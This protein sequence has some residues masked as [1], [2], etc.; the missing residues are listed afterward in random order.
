MRGRGGKKAARQACMLSSS[1]SVDEMKVR[2]INPH[3][4]VPSTSAA[5]N[6]NDLNSNTARALNPAIPISMASLPNATTLKE[7]AP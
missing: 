2:F 3:A 7:I 1:P 5:L 6:T 4:A